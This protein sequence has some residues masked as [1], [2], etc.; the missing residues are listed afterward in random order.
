[1][2]A[3]HWIPLDGPR[4]VVH[5][6]R[7]RQPTPQGR[8]QLSNISLV[9]KGWTGGLDNPPPNPRWTGQHTRHLHLIIPF[10]R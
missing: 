5:A 10:K 2:C 8:G 6:G 7:P 1:M 4:G 3:E 9:D